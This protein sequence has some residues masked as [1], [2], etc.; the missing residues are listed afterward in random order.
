MASTATHHGQ[1]NALIGRRHEAVTDASAW[2]GAD[3]KDGGDWMTVLT[4][5]N[6]ADMEAAL[7]SVRAMGLD[8]TSVQR[9]D[10]PLP[11]LAPRLRR[12]ADALEHGCGFALLR[13]LP[14]DRWGFEDATAIYWCLSTHIGT[15]VSQNA[16]GDRL[17]A[18]RAA[19][20]AAGN[21]D[22]RGPQTNARL[23]Y[24]SDFADI[25]GLLCLHPAKSGGV[26]RICSSIAIH[27]AL[28]ADGR[29]DL[30]DAFYDG[31]PFDRKGEQ[32]DGVSAVSERPIPMLSLHDG[33]LSFRYVPGWSQSAVRRTGVPWTD[34]Q[35]A[36]IDEVNRLSN[37][38]DMYL[39]MDFQPGDVQFLN[40]Y[41][42]LHSRTEF[43][44][45][46]EPERKRFLQ[47][48][49]LRAEQGRDLAP[50][51]DHLFGAASTRDGIPRRHAPAG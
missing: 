45:H 9:C 18:V 34:V 5:E 22:V 30:I 29:T 37:Q 15:P 38:P 17:V 12:I 41:A 31:F 36:A 24:H 1:P 8:M 23:F 40:N 44:D 51:F 26:S 33:R 46:E 4:D 19:P 2:R 6:I 43:V 16:K 20:E 50:D 35:Q 48:I 49:W 27:N 42:V 21:P 28:L 11:S 14:V 32:G 25:V 3:L 7:R 13:G 39:D 47:R 10:F